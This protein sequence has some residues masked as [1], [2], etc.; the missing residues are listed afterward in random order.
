MSMCETKI[1]GL[2]IFTIFLRYFGEREEEAK[3]SK[4]RAKKRRMDDCPKKKAQCETASRHEFAI[5]KYSKQRNCHISLADKKR[6]I[7]VVDVV[8][9]DELRQFGAFLREV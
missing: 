6:V 2:I 1:G 5:K 9:L 4:E 7:V 3:T 8:L